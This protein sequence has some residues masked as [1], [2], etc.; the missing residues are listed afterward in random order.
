MHMIVFPCKYLL[1]VS[2]C[3]YNYVHPHG[4]LGFMSYHTPAFPSLQTHAFCRI[5]FLYPGLPSCQ[6]AIK[7]LLTALLRMLLDPGLSAV[8]HSDVCAVLE[9][10]M[11]PWDEALW[12]HICEDAAATASE[13]GPS[14]RAA[15]RVISVA[16]GLSERLK[17]WQQCAA[18]QLLRKTLPQVLK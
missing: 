17:V 15:Y 18:M 4:V 9:G 11:Q 3:E 5:N 13:L 7:G 10:L 2:V 12:Q 14:H 16:H 8:L 1:C 6:V